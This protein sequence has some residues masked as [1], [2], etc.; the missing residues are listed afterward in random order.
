MA[1]RTGTN[2]RCSSPDVSIMRYEAV[3][4]LKGLFG[5]IFLYK[6]DTNDYRDSKSDADGVISVPDK[7]GYSGRT[8]E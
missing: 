4:G 2:G 7:E 3:Q 6:A 8:E 1:S 5:S